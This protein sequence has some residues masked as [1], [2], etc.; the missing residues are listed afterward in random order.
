MREAAQTARAALSG[1]DDDPSPG[2]ASAVDAVGQ[3]KS[4]MEA[5][6]DSAL[7]ALAAQLDGALAVIADVA[8]ELGD[9]LAAL[10]SDASTL[11][12]KLTRQS[13]L[14]T[15]TRKYAADIDGVLQWATQSRDR[16]AQL[17]VS[18]EALADLERRVVELHDEVVARGERTHQGAH[19]GGQGIVESGDRRTV[20]S[21]DGRRGVHGVGCAAARPRRRLRAADGVLRADCRTPASTA[22]TPSSSASPRTA[23]PTC[24]H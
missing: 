24:F 12:A 9:Y 23:V 4:A 19:Q 3:A 14:R 15:L 7:R 20:G 13:E 8:S 18:E 2:A 17:D 21:G 1:P 22:P 10:P 16:L 5:T 6:D 11:E